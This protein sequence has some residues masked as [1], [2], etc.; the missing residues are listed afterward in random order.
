MINL[1]SRAVLTGL[2]APSL[3]GLAACAEP[4]PERSRA[5]EIPLAEVTG[6]DAASEEGDADTAMDGGRTDPLL[7]AVTRADGALLGNAN[8]ATCTFTSE[9]DRTLFQTAVPDDTEANPRGVARIGGE[10]VLFTAEFTGS[11]ARMEEGGRFVGDGDV[12]ADLLRGETATAEAGDDD[13]GTAVGI[14]TRSWP[15]TLTIGYEGTALATRNQG[16]WTC[17]N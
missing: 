5:D 16:S 15:A 1:S 12:F 6:G 7:S 8:V 17:G 9:N 14:E 10:P 2:L 4:I 3:L 13:G 11:Q